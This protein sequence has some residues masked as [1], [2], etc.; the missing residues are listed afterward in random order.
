MRYDDKKYS[1]PSDKI[2]HKLVFISTLITINLKLRETHKNY[3]NVPNK[4]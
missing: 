1:F 4:T 2:A 3:L